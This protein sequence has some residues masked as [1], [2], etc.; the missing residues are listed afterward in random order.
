MREVQ[1]AEAMQWILY[2]ERARSD[3]SG[4]PFSLLIFSPR[5][6]PWPSDGVAFLVGI[7]RKRLRCYD[8]FGYLDGERVGVVLPDSPPDG[9][10]KVAD[11]VLAAYPMDGEPPHCEVYAYP[12]DLSAL[13]DSAASATPLWDLDERPVR[14]MDALFVRP[15]PRWKRGLDIAGALAGIVLFSP[16]L[17]LGAVAVRLSSPGPILFRQWRSGEG[18]RRFVIYKFRTMYIDAELRKQQL[19]EFSEQ[20]GPAFKIKRDPRITRIGRLLRRT[21]IDELPQL[22]NVLKGE[23]SLVGPRPLPCDESDECLPWQKGRLDVTPGLTCIW[24]VKGRSRVS[25]D[26]WVRMDLRYVRT[27]GLLCDLS[28]IA[29]TVLAVVG[30]RGAH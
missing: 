21:S 16:L 26:E 28:L 13:D 1:N 12:A 18:S 29:Q 7:L 14:R 23:M 9:A 5:Q 27:R 22:F 3:R 19:L 30:G 25:F 15:L 24:Q 17:L 10:W 20:D 11:D 8:E 2:R 4:N 6:S